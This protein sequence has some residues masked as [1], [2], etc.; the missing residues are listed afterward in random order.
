PKIQGPGEPAKDFLIQGPAVHGVAGLVNLFGM[1]SPG[2]T[3]ALAIGEY[4]R[5]LLP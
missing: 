3:S 5:C 2:L 1:E 4:V